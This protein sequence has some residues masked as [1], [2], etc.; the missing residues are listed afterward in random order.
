MDTIIAELRTASVLVQALGVSV[1]GLAG[2]FVTLG[3]FFV[4]IKLADLIGVRKE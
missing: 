4:L 2:V 1:G 3:A